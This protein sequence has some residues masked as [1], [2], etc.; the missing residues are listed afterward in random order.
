M[1]EAFLI[2]RALDGAV[3]TIEEHV[4]APSLAGF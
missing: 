2:M 3:G 4:V 1:K